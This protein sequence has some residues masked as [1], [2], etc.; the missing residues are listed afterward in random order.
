MPAGEP[1][2]SMVCVYVRC[3]S[4]HYFTGT[5]CPLDGWSSPASLAVAEAAARLAGSG[6]VASIARLR[7]EGVSPAA[8]ARTIV[9]DFGDEGSVFQL[10]A[11]KG[12]VVDGE[13]IEEGKFPS[14]FL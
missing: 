13:W 8:L 11:P 4:G 7:S 9:V 5:H 10:V 6:I 14:R 3:N 1:P 12:Y 2:A